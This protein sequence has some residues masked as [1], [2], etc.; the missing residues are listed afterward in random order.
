VILGGSLAGIFLIPGQIDNFV[1]SR[2]RAIDDLVIANGNLQSGNFR[3]AFDNM[4]GFVSE[5]GIRAGK[6]WDLSKLSDAQKRFF[7]QTLVGVLAYNESY[8]PTSLSDFRGKDRWRAMLAEPDFQLLFPSHNGHGS[9]YSLNLYMGLAYARYADSATDLDQ[10]YRYLHAAN[11]TE[12]GPGKT[13]ASVSS[14]GIFEGFMLALLGKRNEAISTMATDPAIE[15][16]TPFELTY[17]NASAQKL[18]GD[19]YAPLLSRLWPKFSKSEFDKDVCSLIAAGYIAA[20]SSKV[21]EIKDQ[22]LRQ[23]F[24]KDVLRKYAH[25][26]SAIQKKTYD[27]INDTM[28]RRVRPNN[29]EAY[30]SRFA[31]LDPNQMSANIYSVTR[32]GQTAVIGVRFF[33]LKS[34]SELATKETCAN[35]NPNAEQEEFWTFRKSDE[36]QDWK[37]AFFAPPT[38]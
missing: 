13:A 18:L 25:I 1:A 31:K 27:E 33:P 35:L 30:F 26:Q 32:T 37:I 3:G 17:G 11:A 38:Q 29:F 34:Q 9:S 28:E 20:S 7:F 5:L 4:N 6:T 36:D 19:F 12:I 15:S 22:N 24:I 2:V 14:V 16:Y 23:A 10:A 8:D 21:S